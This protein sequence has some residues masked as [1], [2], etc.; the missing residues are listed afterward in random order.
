MFYGLCLS[1][2]L[3]VTRSLSTSTVFCEYHVYSLLIVDAR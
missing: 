3:E 1:N 2:S